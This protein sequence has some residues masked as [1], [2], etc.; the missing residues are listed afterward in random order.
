MKR[1]YNQ[2]AKRHGTRLLNRLHK[3]HEKPKNYNV[4]THSILV[5]V[6]WLCIHLNYVSRCSVLKERRNYSKLYLPLFLSFALLCCLLSWI[7]SCLL[8]TKV[9]VKKSWAAEQWFF[10][11]FISFLSVQNYYVIKTNVGNGFK[12]II[13]TH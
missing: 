9:R 5:N 1:F 13:N 4:Y 2:A 6:L 8:P 12:P 10:L 11:H 3:L 7:C